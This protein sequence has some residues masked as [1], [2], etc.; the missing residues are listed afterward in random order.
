MRVFVSN[1]NGADE[2]A[3]DKTKLLTAYFTMPI[4]Y[5]VVQVAEGIV[6]EVHGNGANLRFRYLIVV[7]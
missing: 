4:P 6:I 7:C 5:V 3:C 1:V 2:G